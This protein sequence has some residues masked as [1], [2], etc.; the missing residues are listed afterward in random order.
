MNAALIDPMM[1][2]EDLVR[3][4]FGANECDI[5]VH[6]RELCV[7]RGGDAQGAMLTRSAVAGAMVVFGHLVFLYIS[8]LAVCGSVALT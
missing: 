8:V 3:L 7:A 4:V 2:G 1:L 6:A 5:F